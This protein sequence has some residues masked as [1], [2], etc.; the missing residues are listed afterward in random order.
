LS[1]SWQFGRIVDQI[2]CGFSAVHPWHRQRRIAQTSGAPEGQQDIKN[3]RIGK[4]LTGL[5]GECVKF[6]AGFARVRL[7]SKVPEKEYFA[8]EGKAKA[9]SPE[10]RGP[11]SERTSARSPA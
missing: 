10:I 11:K 9:R 5:S 8:F 6:L 3:P 2:R 1:A 7:K 4:L